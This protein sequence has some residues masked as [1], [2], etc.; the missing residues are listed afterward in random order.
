MSKPPGDKSRVGFAP[1]ASEGGPSPPCTP[2]DPIAA[3][4]QAEI[5]DHLATAA[6]QLQSQGLTTGEAREKSQAKFGDAV[7]I[8]RRCYWIKQGDALMFRT[9][10]IVLLTLLC[11]ALGLVAYGGYRS[12]RQM[13]EQMAA[14]AAELKAMA[15]QQKAVVATPPP[16]AEPK[17]LEITGRVYIGSPDKPA[18]NASL[19]LIDLKDASGV[20]SF[21][22]DD[23]GHF[24]SG[25]LGGGD[26]ALLTDTSEKLPDGARPWTVQSAPIAAY[27]GVEIPPQQIDIEHRF[28]RLSFETTRPLPQLR[29]EGRFTIE[30]R[31]LVRVRSAQDRKAHWT[32]DLRQPKVW[33][34]YIANQPWAD[35][36]VA[37]GGFTGWQ[38]DNQTDRE[39]Y[40]VISPEQLATDLEGTIFRDVAGRFSPGNVA[41]AA[42][43][44]TD[45]FPADYERPSIDAAV[46]AGGPMGRSAVRPE[47]KKWGRYANMPGVWRNTRMQLRKARNSVPNRSATGLG[48]SATEQYAQS[49]AGF[50]DDDEFYWLTKGLGNIWLDHLGGKNDSP[51]LP[52]PHVIWPNWLDIKVDVPVE[53]GQVTCLQ[54]AVPPELESTIKE[55]VETDDGAQFSQITLGD[56]STD[57]TLGR[58]RNSK[59]RTPESRP[60]S[61]LFRPAPLNVRGTRPLQEDQG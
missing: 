11:C 13:A 7:S 53:A 49:L 58:S 57:P 47:E 31:L 48:G 25:P 30:S 14:L 28:G 38:A 23:A 32:R 6:E 16:A 22:A 9:A 56:D 40:A 3:E 52:Y 15:D 10:I 61:P 29:V 33:P 5:A 44:L 19:A 54:I 20:R 2:P 37:S 12:Q 1:P 36:A 26:Y 17:P 35:S 60:D 42:A 45:I 55:L 4:I 50:D 59:P 43:I 39:F 41:I 51:P 27:P 24:Q 46:K 18:A 21:K 8:G 34:I